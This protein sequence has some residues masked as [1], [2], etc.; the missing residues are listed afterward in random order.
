MSGPNLTRAYGD[1]PA[2]FALRMRTTVN[3]LKEDNQMKHRHVCAAL[4]AACLAVIAGT[5]LAAGLGML[6]QPDP[7]GWISWQAQVQ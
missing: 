3:G 7:Q 5:A 6:G 2:Q 4:L 1:C